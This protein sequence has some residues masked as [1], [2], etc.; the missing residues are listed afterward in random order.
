MSERNFFEPRARLLIQLGDKLIKNESIALLELIKNGYDADARKVIVKLS[1]LSE[2]TKGVIEI[3]DDGTGMDMNIIHN[4]WLEPGSDN[5]YQQFIRGKRTKKYNR[6]PIGEKG[7]GRFGVHKLGSKIELVSKMKGKNEVV[8]K[9]DWED[10]SNMKYLK[11]AKFDVYEREP[12]YFKGSRT[13]TRIIV[14]NLRNEWNRTKVRNIYKSIFSLNSPFEKYGSFIVDFKSDNKN[15]FEGLPDWKEVKK[16]ALFHFKGTMRGS[17]IV[18]FEYN[19]TPWRELEKASGRRLDHNDEFIQNRKDILRKIGKKEEIIN[20]AQHYGQN[21]F[22][23]GIGDIEIEG[24]IFDRDKNILELSRVQSKKILKDY[25]DEQGGISVYKDKLRINEYGEKGN[26]WLGLDG[27]R[28]NTPAKRLSNNIVLATI[29]LDSQDSTALVEKTNREGFIEN[30]AFQDFKD[31]ILYFLGLVETLRE[32]DKSELKKKYNPT[33]AKEPVLSKIS[34]LKGLVE[35]KV[36][37]DDKLVEDISVKLD[38]IEEDYIKIQEVLLTSAGAGITLGVGMH[39]VHKILSELVA[40]VVT[41]ESVSDDIA[42]LIYS[43]DDLIKNYTDILK[44]SDSEII[45]LSKLADGGI[46]N[47]SYRFRCHEIELVKPYIDSDKYNIKAPKRLLLGAVSN[48]ID[49]SIYW[50]EKKHKKLKHNDISFT[51]KIFIDILDSGNGTL[52]LV[53]A[54]NGPGFDIPTSN[55]TNPFV[56]SKNEGMGLGLHIVSQIMESLNG[57]IFFPEYGDYDLPNEFKNG[58]IVVLEFNKK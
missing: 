27:R 52:E 31:S 57:R 7:I 9:I 58:A 18:N 56:S 49:N 45:R 53:F 46:R 12:E 22:D 6:L 34:Q 10:F 19:Y 33:E 20:L 15:Y 25:L 51:K 47:N 2:P 35:K 50:L 48:L 8:V 32:I 36:K 14:S 17:K 24:Y 39:E 40:I 41:E 23:K 5:K 44:Q 38:S 3:L 43:L 13:G 4:S 54:D 28:V 55:I 30:K 29:N 26:D 42:N 16:M 1:N 21:L 11:D 37:D